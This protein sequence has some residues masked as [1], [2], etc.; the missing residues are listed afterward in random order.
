V[1]PFTPIASAF[2]FQPLP[3]SYFLYLVAALLG[4]CVLTQ[5]AKGPYIRR[6]HQWL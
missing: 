4:Y 5:L 2:R 3:G 1:L 6:F